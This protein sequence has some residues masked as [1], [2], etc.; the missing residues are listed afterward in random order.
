MSLGGERGGSLLVSPGGVQ[1]SCS[2]RAF[3]VGALLA[4]LL[5]VG[6]NQCKCGPK[7]GVSL[8]L[9]TFVDGNMHW[10]GRMTVQPCL[11]DRGGFRR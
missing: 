11:L 8:T 3:I 7:P 9:L 6:M 5:L 1:D 4:M 10:N 2:A